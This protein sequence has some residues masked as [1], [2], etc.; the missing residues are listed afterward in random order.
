MIR[1]VGQDGSETTDR[2]RI[3]ATFPSGDWR[4]FAQTDELTGE[5]TKGVALLADKVTGLEWPYDD[6]EVWLIVE[7]RGLEQVAFV[8]WGGP[9]VA[10]NVITGYINVSYNV[11]GELYDS[12]EHQTTDNEAVWI[13]AP[14]TFVSR[15]F[16]KRTL[17]YR[18]WNF[19]D[20]VIGT[21]T[22]NL[23]HL[24]NHADSLPC[25]QQ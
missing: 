16:N 20:T 12:K 18:A 7:C 13:I 17:I 15:V 6:S 21:A 8:D 3:Y 25:F 4:P 23:A 22:F 11:D 19:D 9:Y 10:S 24:E 2:E 1:A 14:Q 5:Q